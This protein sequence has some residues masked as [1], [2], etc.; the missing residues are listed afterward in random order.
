[1]YA[2]R[3]R[4]RP[5][6]PEDF[7]ASYGYAGGYA[8]QYGAQE[9]EPPLLFDDP[10]NPNPPMGYSSYNPGGFSYAPMQSGMPMGNVFQ[11]PLIAGVASQY[12]QNLMGQGKEMVDQHLGKYSQKL[13]NLKYYFAVDTKYVVKKIGLLFFPF[14]HRD[15]ALQFSKEEMVQ[16][17]HDI[18]APDL[19]IPTMAFVTY[20]FLAGLVFGLQNKFSP[21]QLG[22]HASS[23]LA[24]LCLEVGLILVTIY[25]TN[26]STDL[27]TYDLVSY[28]SY[29]YVGCELCEFRSC[30]EWPLQ[31]TILCLRGTRDEF[32]S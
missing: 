4:D 16:P 27:V 3:R 20:I 6:P 8:P 11:N 17:K 2:S 32:I 12:G 15:W 18:N 22:M 9:Q 5:P 23:S 21:E 14:T 19:Y 25:L 10:N 1:M 28:C 24:W 13:Q 31:G 7:A 30:L 29:K 26:L